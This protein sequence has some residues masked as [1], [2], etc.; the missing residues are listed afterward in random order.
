MIKVENDKAAV[1]FG[2]NLAETVGW[3]ERTPK[4]WQQNASVSERNRMDW[5]L[6]AGWHGALKLAKE[7]WKEG[8]TRLSNDLAAN[9]GRSD[10]KEPPWR[11]DV[12][13]HLPDVPRFLAGAPDPMMR[14]G[15]SKGRTPVI[16]IVVNISASCGISATEMANYGLAITAL[17]D[18]L[19]AS[20]KR[21]ELDVGATYSRLGRKRGCFG[22]KVK[23]ASEPIDLADVAF[24]IAHPAAFRRFTFAM[25][26]R[27]PR[28]MEDWAYGM[29]GV[30]T[31]DL[32][33]EFG[34]EAAFL[35][36]GVG[37]NPGACRTP[38]GAMTLAR[39][40]LEAAMAKRLA[41]EQA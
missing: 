14:H 23:M 35:L 41:E 7:G 30:V 6:G 33:A 31:Q 24:S 2:D 3:L 37:H 28:D 40:Q 8:T 18:E 22:W 29:P 26:E 21:V 17:I 32:A 38:A 13:G 20:G 11:Y 10:H 19:E 36:D 27:T 16:H 1:Y 15:Q 34:A 12:A 39:G 4:R 5:D 9:F 25:A